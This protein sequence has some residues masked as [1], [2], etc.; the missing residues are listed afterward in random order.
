MVAHVLVITSFHY[1]ETSI[2]MLFDGE[3]EDVSV[4]PNEFITYSSIVRLQLN[5]S[6]D[7]ENRFI[8][9]K[10]V[11]RF[12]NEFITNSNI[13][14]F[15]LDISNQ[16]AFNLGLN[17]TAVP[18]ASRVKLVTNFTSTTKGYIETSQLSKNIKPIPFVNTWTYLVAPD[19]HVI[20][21]NIHAYD[22]NTECFL[23][24]KLFS[25]IFHIEANFT[26]YKICL[27]DNN[28]YT[29]PVIYHGGVRVQYK[30]F[31][32]YHRRSFRIL[33][34]FHHVSALPVQLSEGRW[35]C[36]AVRWED[37]QHHFPCNFV[38][39]CVGGEDEAGCWSGDGTCSPGTLQAGGRCFSLS[40]IEEQEVSWNLASYWCQQRGEQ[41][42]SLSTRRVWDAVMEMCMEIDKCYAFYIGARSAPPAISAMYQNSWIWSDDTMAH[43]IKLRSH[44]KSYVPSNA[45]TRLETSAVFQLRPRGDQS[46][47]VQG[48]AE[49][50]YVNCLLCE[51]PDNTSHMKKQ[52]CQRSKQQ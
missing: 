47:F 44:F 1:G 49:K 24:S 18:E 21:I 10:Y 27:L 31:S 16:C 52:N 7:A 6:N 36:S 43:F 30:S 35:N 3:N 46:L 11:S 32:K 12:P 28:E 23:D 22:T 37:M 42:A 29:E 25:V 26:E 8:L 48:C 41:L 45:C 33:F 34:S 38:S 5:I 9:H 19:D 40:R 14:R 50:T 20:L 15:Q 2:T 39:N 17:F 51:I 4:I 13:V